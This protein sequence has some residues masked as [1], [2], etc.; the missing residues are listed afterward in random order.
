MLE[1]QTKTSVVEK[2]ITVK[3]LQIGMYVNRLDRPWTETP[4]LFQG[5]YIR[6]DAEIAE[7]R[8]YCKYVYIDAEQSP[9]PDLSTSSEHNDQKKVT[10]RTDTATVDVASAYSVAETALNEELIVAEKSHKE[11]LRRVIKIMDQLRGGSKPKIG[12]LK[13]TVDRTVDSVLR[14]PDAMTWLTRMKHTDS[15]IYH[16]SMASSI[17]AIIL[18]RHLGLKREMLETLG[19]GAMLLDIGKTKID[20]DL[21]VKPD[22]LTPAE[23]K[24]MRKHLDYGLEILKNQPNTDERVIEMVATH[25]ER[26]NGTGYPRGLKGTQIPVFGRIA[27]IVDCYDAM[28]SARPYARQ[29]SPFEA[30]QRL[31]NLADVEFQVEMVE[32]FI[33][34]IGVFP[35]GTL[36][37]MSTGEVAV[38]TS[39]NRVRRLRPEIML[40]L[41]SNKQLRK[42]FP[43]IDLRTVTTDPS[44][45][46][47]LW[48]V[49]GLE[50]GA[51]GIDPSQFYL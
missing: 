24:V 45:E 44:H 35:T 50:P 42:E 48:I 37:E 28:I 17:W 34:A 31:T 19:L 29:Y 40:I 8:R 39:Q 49:K 6:D 47:S 27:G 38:V 3:Q 32:Q 5:F 26:H 10:A 12:A 23:A 16:H 7:L 11:G 33:Q 51:Y 30:T 21:L 46:K 4:F 9:N 25:H 1:K 15:Y 2:K 13:E 43:I 36:V 14:N 20:K 18:G 22:K 41:D